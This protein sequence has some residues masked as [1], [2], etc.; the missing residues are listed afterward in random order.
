M[1][2]AMLAERACL[3][4]GAEGVADMIDPTIGGITTPEDDGPA[5]AELIR[6]YVADRTLVASKGRAARALA[7]DRYAP[8]SVANRIEEI[9]TSG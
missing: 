5:L 9:V 8:G 6:P 7:I 2:L 1:I 4:T 3:A